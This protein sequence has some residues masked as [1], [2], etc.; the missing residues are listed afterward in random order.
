M[1]LIKFNFR[2]PHLLQHN[3]LMTKFRTV[4]LL[5]WINSTLYCAR[6]QCLLFFAF[7]RFLFSPALQKFRTMKTVCYILSTANRFNSMFVLQV[8]TYDLPDCRLIVIPAADVYFIHCVISVDS[9]GMSQSDEKI[10]WHSDTEEC[11]RQTWHEIYCN[12][13]V[14]IRSRN[15][16]LEAGTVRS[17]NDSMRGIAG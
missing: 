12:L 8:N 9:F 11:R 10:V 15:F 1:I 2:I 16:D 13:S 7:F 17:Y 3:N 4:L 6:G 14:I 5:T